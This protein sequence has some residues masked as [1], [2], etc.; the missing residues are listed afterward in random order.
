MGNE[1]LL[2]ILLVV[3]VIG[4][5]SYIGFIKFKEVVT[6]SPAPTPQPLN[7]SLTQSPPPPVAQGE[8]Q[9]QQVQQLPLE[10]NK[11]L[12][13]FPG[14][15]KPEILANK[16]AVIKTA[17][18]DI[19][20]EIYPE[21]T[22]AASNFIILASNGFYNGLIFHRVEDWVIQGGD[23]TGTGSGGPG[24][25]FPDE[26]VTRPYTKGTV[27]MANA[28]PNTNGSQFFILLK[29]YPLQ[30]NYTI[31]GKIIKGQEV[32]D[33]ISV[34]DIMNRVTIEPIKQ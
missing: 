31:F 7:F 18:G 26:P 10:E 1:K 25:E 24:Y 30:P 15:L 2:G 17:K 11:R 6:S 34:G 33:K 14:I 29:D 8:D 21:A 22:M 4:A 20:F 28:G 16:K 27:A 19:E 23:P 5:G 9:P 12:S 3:L 13:Q 32:A